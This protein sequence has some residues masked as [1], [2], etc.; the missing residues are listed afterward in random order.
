MACGPYIVD[1][2]SLLALLR[3]LQLC[4]EVVQRLLGDQHA[5]QPQWILPC[6][7]RTTPGS[8]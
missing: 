6:S 3:A 5:D 1:L 4:E 8:V 2:L 7:T